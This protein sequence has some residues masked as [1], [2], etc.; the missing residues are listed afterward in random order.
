[1]TAALSALLG[2]SQR[3]RLHAFA[4]LLIPG[5]AGLPPASEAARYDDAVENTLAARPDLAA[6]VLP[7][8]ASTGEPRVVLN[9]LRHEDPGAFGLFA[10]AVAAAYLMTPQVRRLLGY[11]GIAPRREPPVDLSTAQQ[12]TSLTN[13]KFREAR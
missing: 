2:Q 6:V 1:V 5:G 9:Q 4:D 11:P 7:L 13:P 3:E 12:G 10:Y 8:I